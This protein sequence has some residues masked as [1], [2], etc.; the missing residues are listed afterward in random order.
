[1][2]SIS[3]R[4]DAFRNYS[5]LTGFLSSLLVSG[6]IPSSN[7]TPGF[8][9]FSKL[10]S[11]FSKPSALA[12]L[13]VAHCNKLSNGRPGKCFWSVCISAQMLS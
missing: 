2:I 11:I 12:P 9:P 8:F 3:G 10:P 6:A 13:I 7:K 5:S 4:T 1:M